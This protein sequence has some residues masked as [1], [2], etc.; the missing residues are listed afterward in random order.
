VETIKLLGIRF[1]K[2]TRQQLF[3]VITQSLKTER[4]IIIAH[5]NIHALNLAYEMDWY[6]DFL[7]RADFVFCD[8]FGVVLGA[9]L[10]GHVIK[11]EH[12]LTCPDWIEELALF[13][14][15]HN[16]SLFLLGGKPGVAEEAATKLKMAA[17]ELRIATHHG[18]FQKT[19]A[20]NDQVVARINTFKPHILYVGF[21]MPF[22][23]EWIQNNINQVEAKIFMPLGAC[24]DFYTGRIYRGP[25]WLTDYG[26]EWLCRLLFEPKRLW[27]RYLIGGPLFLYRLLHSD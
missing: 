5:V 26:L 9:R 22:Q 13:Y 17:P 10:M 27:R 20:E 19:N 16:L 6:R 4:K 12:R 11:A 2:L 8:G 1:H 21:G 14:Q 7:N 3:Q 24:F 23:E 15:Q 25:R 18:Y